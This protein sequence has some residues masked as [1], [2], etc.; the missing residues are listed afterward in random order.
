MVLEALNS[1]MQRFIRE[2]E[3][4][5]ASANIWSIHITNEFDLK[6]QDI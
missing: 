2:N 6:R 1:G 4:K 3:I 5:D